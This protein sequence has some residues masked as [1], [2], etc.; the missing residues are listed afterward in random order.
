LDILDEFKVTI[1]GIRIAEKGRVNRN[2]SHERIQIEGVLQELISSSVIEKY[3]CG[4]ISYIMG[5]LKQDAS[6]FKEWVSGQKTPSFLSTEWSKYTDENER[7]A[8][9]TSVAA[10]YY[11]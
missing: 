7:E 4:H 6:S 11:E 5:I 1:A 3:F 9:I 2:I 10:K 8:M